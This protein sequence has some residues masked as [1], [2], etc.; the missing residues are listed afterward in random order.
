MQIIES[1]VFEIFEIFH[2]RELNFLS[3]YLFCISNILENLRSIRYAFARAC[4]KKGKERKKKWRSSFSASEIVDKT[5]QKSRNRAPKMVAVFD[6]YREPG[7]VIRDRFIGRA[8]LTSGILTIWKMGTWGLSGG[9]TERERERGSERGKKG[10]RGTERER[11]ELARREKKRGTYRWKR[12]RGARD[13]EAAGMPGP[14]R[15]CYSPQLR[16]NDTPCLLCSKQPGVDS[17]VAF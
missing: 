15:A 10:K 12:A 5:R 16:F 8:I 1:I 7:R 14:P 11:T 3:L 13:E 2:S 4:L 9:C 6:I 17:L